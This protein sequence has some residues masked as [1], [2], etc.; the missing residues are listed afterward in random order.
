MTF[1]F[2]IRFHS[3][4]YV[5]LFLVRTKSIKANI[6]FFFF[7]LSSNRQSQSIHMR[8]YGVHHQHMHF[9]DLHS[10]SKNFSD[11]LEYELAKTLVFLHSYEHITLNVWTNSN[12]IYDINASRLRTKTNKSQIKIHFP[13]NLLSEINLF[14]IFVNKF[15]ITLRF[16]MFE[17]KNRIKNKN[18]QIRNQL[19]IDIHPSHA[20]QHWHYQQTCVQMSICFI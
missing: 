8:I 16:K 6:L 10:M 20:F 17:N 14:P 11:C 5:I 4:S 3:I 19:H 12:I 2:H 7:F 1:A 13:P 18:F 9:V 15:I